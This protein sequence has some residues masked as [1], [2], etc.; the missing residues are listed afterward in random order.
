VNVTYRIRINFLNDCF[1]FCALQA[2]LTI[3]NWTASAILGAMNFFHH[4]LRTKLRLVYLLMAIFVTN[5]FAA[6][7]GIT[8]PFNWIEHERNYLSVMED[9][10]TQSA[11]DFVPGPPGKEHIKHDCHGS[12]FCHAYVSSD[13]IALQP[14]PL[15]CTLPISYFYPVSGNTADLPFRPPQ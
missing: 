4:V 15:S 10:T 11:Q 7:V 14:A 9:H 12:H 6:S 13:P 2:Q 1:S 8:A 5:I 3:F